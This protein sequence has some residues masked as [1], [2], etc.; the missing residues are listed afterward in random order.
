MFEQH[1]SATLR[2]RE[3]VHYNDVRE[4]AFSEPSVAAQRYQRA[5]RH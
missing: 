3:R 2:V 5:A 1:A 4:V